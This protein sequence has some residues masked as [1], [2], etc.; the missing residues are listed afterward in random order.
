MWSNQRESR[1]TKATYE[2]TIRGR[3]TEMALGT[4][5]GDEDIYRQFIASK[6]PDALS[7]EEEVAL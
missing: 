1:I 3:F 5:P 4:Q 7:T 2:L 6:A